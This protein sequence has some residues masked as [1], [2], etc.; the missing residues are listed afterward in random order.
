MIIGR[1]ARILSETEFIINVGMQDGV[2]RDMEFVIY[3][4]ED[5]VVDPETGEDLGP[6]ETVKGRLEVTH[7]MDKMSRAKTLTYTVRVNP[8]VSLAEEL[9]GTRNETRRHKLEVDQVEPIDENL[10]VQRGDK[11]RSLE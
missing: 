5:H 3:S 7:V 11:V 2:K 1:V 8:A 4:E 10:T 6:I 9:L